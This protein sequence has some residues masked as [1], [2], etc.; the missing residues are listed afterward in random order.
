VTDQIVVT[1]ISGVVALLVALLGI[2]GAIAAQMVATR[3]A[4]ANSL[5][6]FEEQALEARHAREES[7]RIENRH[8][9]ADQK[10]SAHS[11][12]L[13][14]ADEIAAACKAARIAEERRDKALRSPEY[15][16]NY[17]S[18]LAQTV[19]DYENEVQE[20][21]ARAEGLTGDLAEAVVEIELLSENPVSSAASWLQQRAYTATEH[22]ESRYAEAREKFLLAARTEL[23]LQAP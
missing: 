10:R 23:G 22:Q 1:L 4:F 16:D 20:Q 3:R 17:A 5:A 15:G 18:F 9:F 19:R 21:R 11:R 14:L 8:R 7:T 12:A 2:A 13:R 6:L